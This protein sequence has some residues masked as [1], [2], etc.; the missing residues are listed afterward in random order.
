MNI[1]V[2]QRNWPWKPERYRF[3]IEQMLLTLFPH[4]RKKAGQAQ[5][6]TLF[7]GSMGRTDLPGGDEDQIMR[8]LRRLSELE[9]D[10]QVLPGHEGQS[11]LEQER[12]TNYCMRMALRA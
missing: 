9:G 6:R 7:A 11:T 10:Y 12:K 8:S 1:R 5:A 4:H 2:R 3:P